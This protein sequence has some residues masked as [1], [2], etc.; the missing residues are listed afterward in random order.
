MVLVNYNNPKEFNSLLQI[1]YVVLPVLFWSVANW[2][3]TTLIDG[4][5]K[6]SEIFTS[7]CFAL[8]PLILIGIPWILLSNFISA[9]EASFYYFMQSFAVLWCLYLL[10]VGNMTVHQFTPSKT[11][12]SMILTVGAIGFMAFLCLLFFNL[13]QQ[14]LAFDLQ[15]SGDSTAILKE[16]CRMK[17]LKLIFFCILCLLICV[18]GCSNKMVSTDEIKDIQLQQ[19]DTVK[20]VFTNSL[21]PGMKGIAENDNLQLYINDETA[22]IAVLD[23]RNGSIWRSNPAD[24]D[25]D[26]IASGEKKDLLSAQLI[27]AFNNEF[28]QLNHTNSYNDSVARNQIAFKLLPDGIKVYYQFGTMEK[29]LEDL[30]KYISKERF[31]EKS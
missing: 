7:T 25:S 3:L 17:T 5:G 16:D 20:A 27:L 29:T 14:L 15:S 31:E 18:T 10:F 4:E 19:G 28:G 23:K 12:G 9:E 1:V 11:V 2:S 22:E 21:L 13:I 6:F 30:P 8:T 24:R 26:P